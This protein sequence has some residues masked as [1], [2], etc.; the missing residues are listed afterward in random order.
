MSSANIILKL[1]KILHHLPSKPTITVEKQTVLWMET[2]SLSVLC[3]KDLLIQW[4]I[5]ITTVF[6]KAL[7][8]NVTLTMHVILE[9][10]LVKRI[11]NRLSMCENWKRKILIIL[12]TEILLWNRRNMFVDYENVIFAIVGSSLFQEY[13]KLLC[14]MNMMSLFENVGIEISLLWSVLKIDKIIYI[15][16]C[17]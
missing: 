15:I 8:K 11:L 10:S 12:L 14:S 16:F 6:V 4:L 3:T 2:V 9:I 5:N 17:V 7:L 13:I 1:W